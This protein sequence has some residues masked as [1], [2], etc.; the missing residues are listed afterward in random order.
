MRRI[1]ILLGPPGV[2]KGTASKSLL[3]DYGFEWLSSGDVLRNEKET[4]SE[5]G[6]RIAGC[7]DAGRLVPD[8]MIID[9]VA[10]ELAAYPRDCFILLDGFP[11]TLPQAE[12]L[13]ESLKQEGDEVSLVLE[14]Q[15]ETDEL[16][17]R[18]LKRAE[19]EGRNDDTPETL[20]RRL[21]VFRELTAPLVEFYSDQQKLRTV[22][23]MGTPNEVVDQIRRCIQQ[24][25]SVDAVGRKKEAG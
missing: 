12:A 11:R 14:L 5:M 10:K 9:L 21:L 20:K 4:G 23:G 24:S 17:R 8:D 19:E 22:D 2:G 1:V 15:A 6:R 7:I 18:I 13:D 3:V 25:L 16:E